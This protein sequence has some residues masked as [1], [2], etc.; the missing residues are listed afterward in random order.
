MSNL[1]V[2]FRTI[3]DTTWRMFGPVVVGAL[4]GWWIDSTYLTSNAAL[5]GSIIGLIL[6]GLLVWKQYADVTEDSK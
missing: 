1:L 3:G 6:A 4:V 2:I 5:T